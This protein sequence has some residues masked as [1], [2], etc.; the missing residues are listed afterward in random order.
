MTESV[1]LTLS[2]LNELPASDL[3]V[4][5]RRCCSSEAWVSGMVKRRPFSSADALL[6]EAATVWQ[7][8]G[9]LAYLEAFLGHPKIGDVSSLK[10]KY[11]DTHALA[12]NEQ[13][14]AAAASTDVIQELADLNKAYEEKFGFIFIVFASGKS[15]DEM[16]QI[17]K[18]RLPNKRDKEI[19]NAADN[20]QKIT[21]L[22]LKKLLG[23]A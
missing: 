21:E 22:R 4:Y 3:A 12:S 15:A 16:L 14:G 11:S 6:R 23:L 18:Q 9:E 20:Q 5:L 7:G 19:Q 10:K 13:S 17:L 8:L 2:D 1:L